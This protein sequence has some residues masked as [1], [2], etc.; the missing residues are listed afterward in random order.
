MNIYCEWTKVWK[1]RDHDFADADIPPSSGLSRLVCEIKALE[2]CWGS[3]YSY[4]SAIG[5]KM[6]SLLL[7]KI[8]RKRILEK[9]W[10]GF[11]WS[12]MFP[13]NAGDAGSIPG[14]RGFHM[15]RG[16]EA[17]ATSAP[18]LQ[19]GLR[20]RRGYH[21]EKPA[22][23]NQGLGPARCRQRKARVA[24]STAKSK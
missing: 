24:T 13:C 17:T 2:N 6:L 20:T 1:H 15:P 18:S 4:N 7:L 11:P 21:P 9:L 14:P 16:S 10:T 23:G 8:S 5:V 3:F 19:P 22:P 12:S